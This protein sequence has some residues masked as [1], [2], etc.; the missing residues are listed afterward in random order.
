MSYQMACIVGFGE[1]KEKTLEWL[2]FHDLRYV[3]WMIDKGGAKKLSVPA[4]KRFNKLVRRASHLVIPGKCLHCP[5]PASRMSLA[6]H[7]GSRGL[8]RVDFFCD[9]CHQG[10]GCDL[11]PPSFCRPDMFKRYNKQGAECLVRAIKE[12]YFG[13]EVRMTQAR[14]EKFFNT[15]KNFSLKRPT[16]MLYTD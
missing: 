12:A 10:S 1:H 11:V 15:A 9:Q 14:M 8:T 4:L 13:G 16:P 2:F 3:W 7:P 6:Q 5:E